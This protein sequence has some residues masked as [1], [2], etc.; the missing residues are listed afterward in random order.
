MTTPT[1]KKEANNRWF[2]KNREKM[3]AYRKEWYRQNK[4]KIKGQARARHLHRKYGMTEEEYQRLCILQEWQCAVCGREKE[5]TIDHDHITGGVRGLLCG[6]CN[7]ALGL[8]HEDIANLNSAA[9][10]L[11]RGKEMQ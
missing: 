6:D 7:R 9:Q 5:L 8:F 2:Q 10:Y 4:E 11:E 1:W 3:R